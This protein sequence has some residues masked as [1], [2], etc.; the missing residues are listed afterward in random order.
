MRRNVSCDVLNLEN[1]ITEALRIAREQGLGKV[2]EYL[3]RENNK[4]NESYED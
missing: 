4:I 1:K 2:I 3:E